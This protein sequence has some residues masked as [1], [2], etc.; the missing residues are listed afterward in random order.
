MPLGLWYVVMVAATARRASRCPGRRSRSAT[1]AFMTHIFYRCTTS[2]C[3]EPQLL[4]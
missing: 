3:Y 4:S 2:L 1:R